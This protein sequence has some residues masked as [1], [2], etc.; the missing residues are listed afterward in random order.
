M[1]HEE[2]NE[3]HHDHVQDKQ[4][5]RAQLSEAK[6]SH[7]STLMLA[8]N[9]G[10]QGPNSPT[11]EGKLM[12]GKSVLR[13]QQL[14]RPHHRPVYE[15]MQNIDPSHKREGQPLIELGALAP[16]QNASAACS[17]VSASN[18]FQQALLKDRQS[19]REAG[20]AEAR[21]QLGAKKQVKGMKKYNQID[22]PKRL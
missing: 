9:L 11:M 19:E 12:L 15:S 2:G 5:S 14:G 18:I 4:N 10:V 17:L 8:S 3:H 22:Q 7:P 6:Y 13:T 1:R 21:T 16:G 20:K